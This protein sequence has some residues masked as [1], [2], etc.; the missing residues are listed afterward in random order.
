MRPAETGGFADIFLQ[1][2]LGTLSTR[3]RRSRRM[4]T[5]IENEE[6]AANSGLRM[7]TFDC[8]VIGVEM[9]KT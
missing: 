3:V 5:K 6:R 8:I 2:I 1:R 4:K 7:G 9:R